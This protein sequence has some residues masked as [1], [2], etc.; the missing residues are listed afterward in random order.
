MIIIGEKINGSIPSMKKAIQERNEEHIRECAR[1]QAAAGADYIDVC[2]SVAEDVEAKTL[3]WLIDLVQAETDTPICL[4]SPSPDSIIAALP[5]CRR[6]G[7]VNSVSME[8]R[9]IEK[10]FPVI[11]GTRWNCVA[12]L[13]DDGGIPFTSEKRLAVFRQIMQKAE[14]CKITPDR[15]F[16]DPLVETLS[17]RET[18]LA[19]FTECARE[20]RAAYPDIHITSGLSNISFGLPARKLIN[21]AFLVLALNAGMDSAIIDPTN[22]DALGLARAAEALLEKDEYCLEYIQAVRSGLIGPLAV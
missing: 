17:G 14:A 11:A 13:C 19:V 6:P 20:I 22:R 18:T 9:K 21:Q 10:I 15:L 7:L 4:D 3:N 16:I 8:G 5:R 1:K 12:L 2:A